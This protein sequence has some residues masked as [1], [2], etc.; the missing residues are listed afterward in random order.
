MP[1]SEIKKSS[2]M[3]SQARQ[4]SNVSFIYV[5][6]TLLILLSAFYIFQYIQRIANTQDID[7]LGMKTDHFVAW[8]EISDGLP[9]ASKWVM[10]F[11]A[12]KIWS[13]KCPRTELPKLYVLYRLSSLVLG[14][15]FRHCKLWVPPESNNS[16]WPW[17]S[18]V[19]VIKFLGFSKRWDYRVS[20][21]FLQPFF[22]HL[23]SV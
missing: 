5:C 15:S 17:K 23:I 4:I 16:N 2:R 19:Q 13:I 20:R 10:S 9:H 22:L 6:R 14:R 3:C 21:F 11:G 8:T 1:P 18:F 7:W 12:L